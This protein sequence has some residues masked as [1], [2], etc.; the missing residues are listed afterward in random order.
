[1]VSVPEDRGV[2]RRRDAADIKKKHYIHTLLLSFTATL[3]VQFSYL[4]LF[5]CAVIIDSATGS[6][7]KYPSCLSSSSFNSPAASRKF[8]YIL[9]EEIYNLF[10]LFT[11]CSVWRAD[12]KKLSFKIFL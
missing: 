11:H 3:M 10:Y 5:Q 12:G 2:C 6:F 9:M 7:F 8:F 4:F 1:M